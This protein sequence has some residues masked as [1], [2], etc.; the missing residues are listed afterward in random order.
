MTVAPKVIVP[1]EL[2]QRGSALW[3]ELQTKYEFDPHEVEL[4]LETCRTLDV[5]EALSE[6][7]ETEGVMLTGSQGQVVL[8]GAI[9]ER[10]QQQAS[11]A[12]LVGQLNLLDAELGQAM[13]ARAVAARSAGQARWRAGK[14]AKRA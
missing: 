4:L 6:S 3:T 7:I 8:N 5:I 1:L 2:R 11:F 10:R 13:S 9:A 12:R 14:A